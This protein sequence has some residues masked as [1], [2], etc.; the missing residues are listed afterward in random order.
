MRMKGLQDKK[1]D[2]VYT[3]RCYTETSLE[4][5]IFKRSK[6]MNS[7]KYLDVLIVNVCHNI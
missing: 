5:G 7:Y 6:I 4:L 2:P 1:N 3:P